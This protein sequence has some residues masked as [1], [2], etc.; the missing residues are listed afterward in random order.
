[1]LPLR[2]FSVKAVGAYGIGIALAPLVGVGIVLWQR[3][4]RT[5]PGPPASWSEVTPN[6]GWLLVGSVMAA[7][8]VNAAPLALSIWMQSTGQTGTHSS[9]PVQYCSITVCIHL[10]D[11]TM[12]SVG[13]A[14]MHKVQPMHQASSMNTVVRGA[15]TPWA[16]FSG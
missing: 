5:D 8:L 6:L 1:M 2:S 3:E 11:P 4:L 7:L 9:Q 15:S 10:L 13:H 16:L 14:L 12:A